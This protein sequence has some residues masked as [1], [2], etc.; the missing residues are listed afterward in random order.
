VGTGIARKDSSDLVVSGNSIT[1]PAGYYS[2][3][4]SSAVSSMTLPTSA[5]ASATSGFTSKATIS[6]S[7]S[8]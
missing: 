7:T 8:D 1:A 3:D 4:A 5:V 2:A 6:R